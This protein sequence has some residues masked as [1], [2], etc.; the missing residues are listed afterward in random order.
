MNG[1]IRLIEEDTTDARVAE[2]VAN[3]LNGSDVE[4]IDDVYRALMAR[5]HP[6][7]FVYRGGH[8]VAIHRR[9]GDPVRLA[10]V[11]EADAAFA[12][13]FT[14]PIRITEAA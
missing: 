2:T 12:I 11:T 4:T 8:H 7:F 6:D 13:K 14:A 3:T 10:F 5:L 1:N 9:S